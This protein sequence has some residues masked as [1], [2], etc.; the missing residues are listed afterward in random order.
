MLRAASEGAASGLYRERQVDLTETPILEWSWRVEN[1]LGALDER[2]KDG[3]DYPPRVYVVFSG[4]LFFWR[5]R[6]I[7][8]VWS[9]H[10]PVG[11]T[12]ENAY[13]GNARMVAVESGP[14]RTGRWLE[15]RRNV[16]ADYRRLFGE[17][18]ERADA[19]ALMT[20]TDNSGG[21]A[22]A[23]YGDIRFTAQ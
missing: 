10:Q 19:V 22:I 3:D 15:E 6:A 18:V 7:N 1:T 14:E 9:N 5:T 23:F 4:G 12:W 17:S 2:R 21:R 20:D 8:Y 13:T 16:R 11:S